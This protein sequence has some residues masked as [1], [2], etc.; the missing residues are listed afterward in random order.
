[1]KKLILIFGTLITM[2]IFSSCG[3]DENIE[4]QIS[5][6]ATT[7]IINTTTEIMAA[8]TKGLPSG[9]YPKNKQIVYFTSHGTRWVLFLKPGQ[10]WTQEDRIIRVN[11]IDLGE[12]RVLLDAT[13][14]GR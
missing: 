11:G 3:S 10:R 6:Q 1:M 8:P 13:I 7:H 14:V 2:L 5:D 12:R 4:T 9:Q